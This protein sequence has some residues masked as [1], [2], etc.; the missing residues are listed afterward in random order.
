M[1]K[2]S[3]ALAIIISFIV[4]VTFCFALTAEDVSAATAKPGKVKASSI[5]VINKTSTTLTVKWAKP[6]Y[7]K[8]YKVAYRIG[9]GDWKY[10]SISSTKKTVSLALKRLK[11]DKKYTIKIRAY[12]GKKYSDWSK[13]VYASTTYSTNY[14]KK[15]SGGTSSATIKGGTAKNCKVQISFYR[16]MSTENVTATYTAYNK[17]K[18]SDSV[19]RIS[20]TITFYKKKIVVKLNNV[21]NYYF[22]MSLKEFLGGLTHTFVL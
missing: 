9:T 1:K 8:K 22:D 14:K 18:F 6:S 7:A 15:V 10:R 5:K 2:I 12:N 21:D 11:S 3:A 19:S 20:G 17:A 13:K 4:G 16:L